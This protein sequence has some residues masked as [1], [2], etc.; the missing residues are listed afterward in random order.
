M[1]PKFFE[2][3]LG[4]KLEHAEASGNTARRDSLLRRGIQNSNTFFQAEDESSENFAAEN[5]SPTANL[6]S[7]TS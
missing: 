4:T 1:A 7:K 6:S 2:N 5:N 3:R